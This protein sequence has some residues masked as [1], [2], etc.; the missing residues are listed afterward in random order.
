MIEAK[1]EKSRMEF[2]SFLMINK[3][4]EGARGRSVFCRN[5]LQ[6]STGE[7]D[8]NIEIDLE[9]VLAYRMENLRRTKTTI[10]PRI[11]NV[12]GDTTAPAMN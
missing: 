6:L 2:E 8:G 7:F 3:G 4:K 5:E 1:N 10:M 12:E 11:V 9:T